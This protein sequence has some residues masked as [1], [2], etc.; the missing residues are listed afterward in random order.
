MVAYSVGGVPLPRALRARCSIARI[1]DPRGHDVLPA[2]LPGTREPGLEG[3][4][5]NAGL[6]RSSSASA[7]IESAMVTTAATTG[8]HTTAFAAVRRDHAELRTWRRP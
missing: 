5:I 1:S 6:G 4:G 8:T 7:A 2:E 3:R